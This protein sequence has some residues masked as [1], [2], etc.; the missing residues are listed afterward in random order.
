MFAIAFMAVL[1]GL[2]Y[3]CEFSDWGKAQNAAQEAEYRAESK[4]HI[5]REV[6]SCK[7]YAWRDDGGRGT[8]HYFTRCPNSVVT[9]E[10]NYTEQCG[11]NC[12]RHKTE[13]IVTETR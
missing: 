3:G 8:T 6:D 9:T 13:T 4:P 1:A 5:V 10:R 12:T 11:K 7:V 2:I